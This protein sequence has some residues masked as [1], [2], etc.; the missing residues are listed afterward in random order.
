MKFTIILALA[1]GAFAVPQATITNAPVA[2]LPTN[3]TPQ[4]SCALSCKPGDVTCQAA[5]LGIARPNASQVVDTNNCAAK[6]DQGNGSPA[7][8]TAYARCVDGCIASLFPSSQTA[9]GPGAA[10]GSAGASAT[11]ANTAAATGKFAL[12]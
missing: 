9:F 8:A 3:V 7:A 4:V 10:Q 1:V 6:C 5:C 12:G 2:P 11:G